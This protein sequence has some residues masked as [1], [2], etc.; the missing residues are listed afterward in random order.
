MTAK[1]SAPVAASTAFCI[2]CEM[3]HSVMLRV[4]SLLLVQRLI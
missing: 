2:G 1:W 4:V 3:S